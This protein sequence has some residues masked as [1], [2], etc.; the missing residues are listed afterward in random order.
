MIVTTSDIIKEALTWEGTPYHHQAAVKGVGVDCAYFVGKIAE[1]VGL[2]KNFHVEPY[3]IEWHMHNEGEKM[4]AIIEGFGA[5]LVEVARPGD[6]LAFKYGRSC[7]HLGIML[8]DNKFI[9]A[10]IK[11]KRVMIEELRDDYLE[12]H[13]HTYIYPG[14]IHD[15]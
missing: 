2:L 10:S 4:L 5:R 3:S 15:Y 7:S 6:I 13:K 11:H 9:H 14:V 8:H 12:R 1:E